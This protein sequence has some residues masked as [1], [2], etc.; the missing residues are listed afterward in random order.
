MAAAA[1][2]EEAPRIGEAQQP[3]RT[4]DLIPQVS[5][6]TETVDKLASMLGLLIREAEEQWFNSLGI[7]LGEIGR[8]TLVRWKDETLGAETVHRL[9]LVASD[10]NEAAARLTWDKARWEHPSLEI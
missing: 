3:Y 1:K 5:A 10:K 9:M 6:V 2:Q 4:I 7:S 8:F